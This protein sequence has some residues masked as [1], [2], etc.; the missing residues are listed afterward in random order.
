M[1]RSVETAQNRLVTFWKQDSTQLRKSVVMYLEASEKKFE[2]EDQQ[3]KIMKT[4][5][6]SWRR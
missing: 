1:C 3:R 5:A 2:R 6:V 4:G